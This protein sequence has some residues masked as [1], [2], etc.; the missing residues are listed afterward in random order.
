[1]CDRLGTSP[2]AVQTAALLLSFGNLDSRRDPVPS[3]FPVNNRACF[4]VSGVKCA[5]V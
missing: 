3:L 5:V 4:A 2:R 1:M